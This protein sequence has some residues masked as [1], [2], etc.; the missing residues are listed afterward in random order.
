MQD[1]ISV[2]LVDLLLIGF[3]LF[4]ITAHLLHLFHR[5]LRHHLLRTLYPQLRLSRLLRARRA[6]QIL[7]FFQ[8]LVELGLRVLSKELQQFDMVGQIRQRCVV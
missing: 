4:R 2:N 1:L 6:H 7:R 8:L 5:W 3:R